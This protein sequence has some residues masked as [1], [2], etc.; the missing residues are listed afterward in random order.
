MYAGGI[1]WKNCQCPQ[2]DERRLLEQA[3]RDVERQQAPQNPNIARAQ[4]VLERAHYLEEHHECE[5][6]SFEKIGGIF[7]C[8]RCGRLCR[9]Y[10]NRCDDCNMDLC[11][12]CL[13][14]L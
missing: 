10:I 8:D 1:K 4:Q 13:R 5:H 6:D 14:H 7:D 11:Y 2:W 9:T 3:E 12:A